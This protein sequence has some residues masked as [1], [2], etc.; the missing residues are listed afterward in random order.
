VRFNHARRTLRCC[1]G[2]LLVPSAT[3]RS[4][5]PPTPPC[6]SL[7]VPVHAVAL[8]FLYDTLCVA[9][10]GLCR[11]LL[12]LFNVTLRGFVYSVYILFGSIFLMPIVVCRDG[13]RLAF[14]FAF[15]PVLPVSFR[16]SG[17]GLRF[18]VRFYLQNTVCYALADAYAGRY[19]RA[20][21]DCAPALLPLRH[22]FRRCCWCCSCRAYR[23]IADAS[24]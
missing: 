10:A 19:L 1:V 8:T 20:I 18:V 13:F 9:V 24:L 14:G 12:R 5:R 3:L 15:I 2:L 23:R 21:N 6:P 4:G 17:G 7:V 22:T 16:L 11:V